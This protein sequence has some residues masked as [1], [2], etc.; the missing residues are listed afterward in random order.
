M[1][2][3]QTCALPIWPLGHPEGTGE[4]IEALGVYGP[5]ELAALA[6][7]E[8]ATVA[9]LLLRAPVTTERA[10]ERW[11]PG[12]T[13]EGPVIVRGTVKA[14]YTRF[15]PGVRRYEVLLG[16]DKGD[17][18]CRWVGPVP[19]EVAGLTAGSEA[20]FAGRLELDEERPVL[21]EAEP[22][23]IDGR[24]GDW[25]PAYG[26]EGIDESRARAGMRAALRKHAGALQ[27]HLPPEVLERHR[28]IGLAQALRDVH[29]PSNATRKG[30]QRLGFDEL[31]QVQLGVA[32]L[33]SRDRRER[34]LNN[35]VGHALVAQA[36]A[37]A[38][39]TFTDQQEAA[40][41]DVQIGR[42]HV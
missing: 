19:A 41:D 24:G 6:A 10:G 31:F 39:W 16:H 9:D 21:Y 14:R 2:G 11:I 18:A 36:H 38:G 23:G 27:D 37:M 35:P 8:I 42:A 7:A 15:S 33:R 20:G 34:G 26:I 25:F 3:V 5:E 1:T 28:L 29:F 13:P 30:R 40:F 17:V 22:L 12:V 4:P 32:L